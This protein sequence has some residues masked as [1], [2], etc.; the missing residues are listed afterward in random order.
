MKLHEIKNIHQLDE[1]LKQKL[2]GLI[3]GALISATAVGGTLDKAETQAA[4]Q[5]MTPAERATLKTDITHS[6]VKMDFQDYLKKEAE[7]KKVS[8]EVKKDLTDKVKLKKITDEI[9]K[10]IKD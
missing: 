5:K 9:R 3:V 6:E 2:A 10:L 7:A 4:L 1:G 8:P